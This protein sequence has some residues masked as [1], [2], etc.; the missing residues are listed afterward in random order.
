MK[1]SIKQLHSEVWQR[2]QGTLLSQYE[3]DKKISQHIAKQTE[4]L[5]DIK[6]S[7]KFFTKQLNTEVWQ[8]RLVDYYW[9]RYISKY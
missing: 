1:F 7:V 9:K 6:S 4:N 5:L 3:V 2:R 8:H